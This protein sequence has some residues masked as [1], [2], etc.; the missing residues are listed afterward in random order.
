MARFR[1]E[2]PRWGDVAL[3]LACVVVMHVE[4]PL[5]PKADPSL[6]GSVAV[7]VA[8]LPVLLRRQAP[9]VAYALSFVAMY[10]VIATVSVYNTMPAPV[11][12]CAYS[13]AERHGLRAALV[14]GAC[15]LPLVL[16][17]LQVFSPHD[18]LSWGTAR[19]LAL[20]PLPLALGVA[21]HARRGYTTMLVERA[22]AAEHSREAEA[23]RRVDE[24]RLRIARDVHDVVAHAMVTINVQAGVGAHL[25]DRDPAQAYDTLRS[26]KQVSGDA[27]TDLRAML[28][29]LREDATGDA[30]AP[31]VQR[32]ADLG[33][34]RD[35]L[36]AAGVDVAFDIDPGARA[37][38]A[39]V[40][41]TCF[42]IVQEALTN[43]LRHAGSTSARV[44][45]SRAEDRVVVEVLDDGGVASPPLSGSGSGH[46][47][48]GMRERVTALGGTLEA[49]PRPDGGWRVAAWLPV[50][51]EP[52]RPVRDDAGVPAP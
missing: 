33:D 14:T 18:I 2:R 50:G 26:I 35:S 38:P 28:G 39:A 48:R 43:T 21:A 8:S 25:L 32:L 19:N 29:L 22:E 20:V 44:R 49:G 15:S 13:V 37:L 12:L 23:L 30:P 5:N 24:E 45:V 47:L 36:A 46:G 1:L 27:L 16:A 10:G 6:L 52:S 31:P 4:M 7:V 9:V 51:S 17:I 3:A 41:A 34:L 42:R 11:V 40:D